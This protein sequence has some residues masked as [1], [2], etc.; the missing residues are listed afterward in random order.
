[1]PREWLRTFFLEENG[2]KALSIL[3]ELV[4]EAEFQS[5]SM[6][7]SGV[8]LLLDPTDG[9]PGDSIRVECKGVTRSVLGKLQFRVDQSLIPLWQGDLHEGDNEL[10]FSLPRSSEMVSGQHRVEL[11]I[12][13]ERVAARQFYLLT[14]AARP[15][16]SVL[17]KRAKVGD[18]VTV[19]S[20]NIPASPYPGR[21]PVTVFLWQGGNGQG[22][23]HLDV[24]ADSRGEATFVVPTAINNRFLLESGPHRLSV[25]SQGAEAHT[26]IHV[27]IPPRRPPA[28]LHCRQGSGDKLLAV[29]TYEVEISPGQLRVKLDLVARVSGLSLEPQTGG[30]MQFGKSTILFQSPLPATGLDPIPL[31]EGETVTRDLV[32]T[33]EK[34][35]DVPFPIA[36]TPFTFLALVWVGDTIKPRQIQLDVPA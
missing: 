30:L 29:S 13:D 31:P 24:G 36:R 14:S 4:S 21:D 2:A 23:A 9:S 26:F 18:S 1:V 17:P 15:H 10:L 5:A 35:L 12:E 6:S 25:Y 34:R 19:Q 11:L 20:D 16:L 3:S 28:R 32:F 33:L 22:V 27:E 8:Q 7:A